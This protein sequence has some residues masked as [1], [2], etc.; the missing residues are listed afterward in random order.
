MI[1]VRNGREVLL[2]RFFSQTNCA[3]ETQV[4]VRV[5]EEL[6][7]GSE[8]SRV[9]GYH[10]AVHPGRKKE[11]ECETNVPREKGLKNPERLRVECVAKNAEGRNKTSCGAGVSARMQASKKTLYLLQGKVSGQ[12]PAGLY[13]MCFVEVRLRLVSHLSSHDVM[14]SPTSKGAWRIPS[15]TSPN[16]GS[17]KPSGCSNNI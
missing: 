4:I 12:A 1:V 13:M 6:T 5:L 14:K 15:N 2:L 17:P 8:K 10:N 11:Q 3:P 16:L 9:W 7:P